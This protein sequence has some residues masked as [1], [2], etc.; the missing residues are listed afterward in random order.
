M[1]CLSIPFPLC[2]PSPGWTSLSHL[3]CTGAHCNGQTSCRDWRGSH[4][5]LSIHSKRHWELE[6]HAYLLSTASRRLS[7]LEPQLPICSVPFEALILPTVSD[8]WD[9]FS[10]I[11][12][13]CSLQKSELDNPSKWEEK[14]PRADIPLL[15]L[16][17]LASIG[18]FSKHGS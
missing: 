16:G 2:A 6:R 3:L 13:L 15:F 12:A 4:L 1:T 8:V 18:R 11:K 7:E 10:P 5:P 17:N 14:W 9:L